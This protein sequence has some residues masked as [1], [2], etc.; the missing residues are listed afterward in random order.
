MLEG[1][2]MN[3]NGRRRRRRLVSLQL[4]VVVTAAAV[5]AA[6]AAGWL[7]AGSAEAVPSHKLADKITIAVTGA[8]ATQDVPLL[9]AKKGYFAQYGLDVDVKILPSSQALPAIASGQVQF[10]EGAEPQAM[11]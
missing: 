2:S 6:S 4:L 3:G 5:L 9:A 1:G 11:N 7:G 10:I 8:T